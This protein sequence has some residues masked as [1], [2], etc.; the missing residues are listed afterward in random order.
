VNLHSKK[1]TGVHGNTGKAGKKKRRSPN[2]EGLLEELKRITSIKKMLAAM[3][4]K[5]EIKD[6]LKQLHGIQWRQAES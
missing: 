2:P 3:M 4:Y 5:H 1:T 6:V